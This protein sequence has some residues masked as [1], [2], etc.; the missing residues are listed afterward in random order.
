MSKKLL[1]TLLPLTFLVAACGGGQPA[2]SSSHPTG[3]ST[4]SEPPTGLSVSS[5]PATGLSV[6]SDPGTSADPQSSDSSQEEHE[7][8][9]HS[10]KLGDADP[11][12]LWQDESYDPET[13]LWSGAVAKFTTGPLSV[14][15]GESILVTAVG[16]DETPVNVYKNGFNANNNVEGTEPTAYTIKESADDAVLDLYQY[17]DGWAFNLSGLSSEVDPGGD[18]ADPEIPASALFTVPG[19]WNK[20]TIYV[21]AWS[22]EG[23]DKEE[24]AAWP[25]VQLTDPTTNG[26]GETQYSFA[27][28][29]YTNF[30]LSDG[31]KQ[32]VDLLASQLAGKSGCY[33]NGTKDDAGHWNLLFW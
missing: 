8:T 22:G 20:D 4:S 29:N 7:L 31:T 13:D 25:G 16:E 3:L 26:Y 9:A 5:D 2:Q 19:A 28:G 6:S 11:V 33:C 21:Y 14:T 18:P 17:S 30:I 27:V 24:N 1:L 15:A 10:V 23:D 12:Y 32:T